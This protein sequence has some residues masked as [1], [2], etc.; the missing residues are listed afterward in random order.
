MKHPFTR[1]IAIVLLFFVFSLY[2]QHEC[3][4]AERVALVIGINE[5][6]HAPR[7]SNPRNDAYLVGRT[8]KSMGFDVSY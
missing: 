5:Y 6:A 4:A 8:L 2:T 3:A 7:L 1:V